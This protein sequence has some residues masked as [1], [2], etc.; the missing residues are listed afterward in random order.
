MLVGK[1][2]QAVHELIPAPVDE[3]DVERQN[4]CGYDLIADEFSDEERITTANFHCLDAGFFR[5][6]IS[7]SGTTWPL[8]A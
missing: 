3:S 8:G 1:F 6:E 7:A 4:R 2:L 5:G